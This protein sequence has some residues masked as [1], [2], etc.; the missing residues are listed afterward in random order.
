MLT[1]LKELISLLVVPG[2]YEVISFGNNE[3]TVVP[4]DEDAIIIS[5]AAHEQAR[6]FFHN[7]P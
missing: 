2:R 5:P 1:N 6:E 3:F 7:S 4:V